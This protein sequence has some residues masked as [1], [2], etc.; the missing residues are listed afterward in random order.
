MSLY[1]I[2]NHLLYNAVI[3]KVAFVYKF[4]CLLP[5]VRTFRDLLPKKVACGDVMKII[6]FH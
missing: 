1:L 4:L 6:L 3:H 5:Q 2:L